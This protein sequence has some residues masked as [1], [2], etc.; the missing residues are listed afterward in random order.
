MF[1][2]AGETLLVRVGSDS[3]CILNI[4]EVVDCIDPETSE[5]LTDSTGKRIT[6]KRPRLRMDMLPESGL[7][8]LSQQPGSMYVH[9]A[10]D[11]EGFLRIY[12]SHNMTGLRFTEVPLC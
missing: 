4:L 1:E 10:D 3:A 9:D 7:F 2:I 8:K 6:L 12:S 5:W 11:G